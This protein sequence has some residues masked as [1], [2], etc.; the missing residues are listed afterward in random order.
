MEQCV[1]VSMLEEFIKKIERAIQKEAYCLL[2]TL[3]KD[4]M[5]MFKEQPVQPL[6]DNAK[7]LKR[8]F[9]EKFDNRIGFF[10]IRQISHC[11]PF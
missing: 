3:Q 9:I 5:T 7:Q 6:I 2:I 11:L 4:L 10:S 1:A 8:Q